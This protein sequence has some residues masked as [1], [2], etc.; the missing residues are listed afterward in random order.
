MSSFLGTGGTYGLIQTPSSSSGCS[1]T[2]SIS[3]SVS[4]LAIHTKKARTPRKRP[5]QSFMEAATL[6][7]TAFP[8]VFSVKNLH[9]KYSGSVSSRSSSSLSTSSD[10]IPA[11]PSLNKSDFLIEEPSPDRSPSFQFK[12]KPISTF[13]KS[14]IAVHVGSPPGSPPS[15]DIDSIFND[16]VVEGI[17]SIIGKLSVNDWYS[18]CN[19]NIN[20][21][22]N[23]F[24]GSPLGLGIR[25]KFGLGLG[26][27]QERNSIWRVLRGDHSEDLSWQMPMVQMNDIVPKFELLPS[28]EKKKTKKKMKKV[29]EVMKDESK[30]VKSGAAADITACPSKL[31]GH[32]Y[33]GLGLK[34]NHEEV[35]KAWGDQGFPISSDSGALESSA[36]IA[37][38]I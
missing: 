21:H 33:S 3:S 37:V 6:L 29:E 18:D 2:I 23:P 24:V 11:F 31:E 13:E 27:G 12:L 17:D 36:D 28:M 8:A 32:L 9:K 10:A 25:G 38:C 20:V 5:N 7:S 30:V 16:E 15:Y 4:S 1:S 35:V 26:V 19:P 34:L 22:I 14:D